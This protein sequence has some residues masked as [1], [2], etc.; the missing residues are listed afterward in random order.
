MIMLGHIAVKDW[1]ED[2]PASL[3]PTA[4]HYLR[5]EL[6]FTGVTITDGLDMG[7]LE[8]TSGEIA[9][10]AMNAGADILLTPADARGAR[11]GLLAALESGD[12]D[13]ERLEEAAG[14]VMVMMRHQAYLADE[15][16]PVSDDDVGS[17]R[18]AAEK[19][20]GS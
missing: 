4:Y 8:G 16:G 17:A 3:S 13:R 5:E 7:A 1:D 9:V 19:L 6:G 12:L 15:A 10:L 11:D 14:R 18:E 2:S 20:G